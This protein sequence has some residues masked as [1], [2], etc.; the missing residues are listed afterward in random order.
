MS[1]ETKIYEAMHDMISTWLHQAK[2]ED[3]IDTIAAYNCL[4]HAL[5]RSIN[6]L[7]EAKYNELEKQIEAMKK[8]LEYLDDKVGDEDEEDLDMLELEQINQGGR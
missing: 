8:H 7:H 2:T 5:T 3:K 4:I 1:V 6:D